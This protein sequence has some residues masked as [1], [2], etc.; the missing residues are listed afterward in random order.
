[1]LRRTV[2]VCVLLFAAGAQVAWAGICFEQEIW[3]PG[4]EGQMARITKVV[5]LI[6]GDKARSESRVDGKVGIFITNLESGD[7]RFVMPDRKVYVEMSLPGSRPGQQA[8][9][10]VTVTK[11][12][13]TKTINGYLCTR[14]DASTSGRTIRCWMTTDV[15]LGEEVATYWQAG[16]RLYPP[17]LTRK[18][19]KVP[20]FPIRIEVL[21]PGP[22][23]TVTVTGL[24]KQDVPDSVFVVPPGYQEV[25]VAAP[26]PGVLGSGNT[27]Q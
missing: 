7:L 5:G 25:F 3:T 6:S 10:D 21:S 2:T 11:T 12:D 26:P 8:S 27:K 17:A 14:Y 18:L 24:K 15:N 16:T 23:T 4:S 19:A 1:M 20:G 13:R 9:F 22:V